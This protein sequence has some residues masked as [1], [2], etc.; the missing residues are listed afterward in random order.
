MVTPSELR[1]G[2]AIH[3]VRLG[4]IESLIQNKIAESHNLEYKSPSSNVD[5]DCNYLARTISGFLNT[6][7]GILVY[8]VSE[9]KEGKHP[10]PDAIKWCDTPKERLEDL[11]KSR[12]QPW[13]E[14]VKIR[15]IESEGNAE[16][17]IFIVEIPKSDNP[18]HMHNYSYFQ[19]LNF[20]TEP[21]S[22]QNIHRAF[23]TSWIR[24]RD[25]NQDVIEPLYA[26]IKE[27]CEKIVNYALGST[28]N[29]HKIIHGNR[30]LY[31]QIE[32]SLYKKIEDFYTR[33]IELNTKLAWKDRIATRIIN[34]ELCNASADNKDWIHDKGMDK[35]HLRAKVKSKY[36]D[37]RIQTT[38]HEYAPASAL[39]MRTTMQSY[40]QTQYPHA[41]VLECQPI[42]YMR[43][44]VE[45][46]NSDF[47][48]LWKNC[49]E[50]LRE[51]K[52]YEATQKEIPKLAT[53]GRQILRL[54]LGM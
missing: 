21:M 2:K 27:N 45:I 7:G 14:T 52:V 8:G 9:K 17:G 19:R 33:M 15:R 10:Y 18:P 28:D 26:E 49:V 51:N 16:E 46:P 30:Y 38:V 20:K 36:P 25:I 32:L 41:E 4:D 34:E 42:L 43:E 37:G 5:D 35:N 22:H 11:L 40:L 12:V 3:R 6:D 47:S 24:R 23:Q 29:Y 39:S 1:F 13:K 31:D 44:I 50:K 54:I 53:L 48:K